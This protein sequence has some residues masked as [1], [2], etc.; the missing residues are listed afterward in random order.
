MQMTSVSFADFFEQTRRYLP[1]QRLATQTKTRLQ[2]AHEHQGTSVHLC[3]ELSGVALIGVFLLLKFEKRTKILS[4]FIALCCELRSWLFRGRQR[5]LVGH[6]ALSPHDI[7][8]AISKH[9][10]L[11]LRAQ[12]ETHFPTY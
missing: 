3:I 4:V 2:E 9:R 1:T 11:S 5:A 12:S 6:R 8:A 7:F 10:I